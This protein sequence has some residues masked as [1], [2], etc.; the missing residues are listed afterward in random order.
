MCISPDAYVWGRVYERLVDAG[1][2]RTKAEAVAYKVS[3]RYR[4]R[5]AEARDRRL[6]DYAARRET[7]REKLAPTP[8]TKSDRAR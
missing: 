3:R 7:A 2:E 1:V 4:A 5:Q 8:M 6:A